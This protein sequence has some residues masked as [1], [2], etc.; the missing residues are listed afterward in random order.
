MVISLNSAVLGGFTV[1]L[2]PTSTGLA[3]TMS[4]GIENV[5]EVLF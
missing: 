1:I 4:S 2:L 3:T 5:K